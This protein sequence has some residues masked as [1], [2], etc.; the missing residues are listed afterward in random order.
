MVPQYIIY[1]SKLKLFINYS[2]IKQRPYNRNEYM[3]RYE[4]LLLSL[5]CCISKLPEKVN[6]KTLHIK[7]NFLLYNLLKVYT[8]LNFL[9]IDIILDLNNFIK[10]KVRTSYVKLRRNISLH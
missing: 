8:L 9:L 1:I 5:A 3:K 10:N 4:S 2:P 7:K 6:R